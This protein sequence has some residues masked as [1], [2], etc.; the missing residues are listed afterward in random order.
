MIHKYTI[1]V[2]TLFALLVALA[3]PAYAADELR[4]S[5]MR[6][7]KGEYTATLEEM[8]VK[9][10][11]AYGFLDAPA[12]DAAQ[13]QPADETSELPKEDAQTETLDE[14]KESEETLQEEQ[15][16]GD[17]ELEKDCTLPTRTD[18]NPDRLD[19]ALMLYRACGT[20]PETSCPFTD[21]PEEYADAVTWLYETGATK[22]VGNQQ[23]GTGEV[24]E[25]QFIVMLSRL[26]RWETDDIGIIKD[27]MQERGLAPLIAVDGA[28]TF[29]EMYQIVCSLLDH[30]YP[31]RCIPTN[32]KELTPKTMELH[33]DSGADAV[34]QLRKAVTYLPRTVELYFSDDCPQD[35][36]AIFRENLDWSGGRKTMPLLS[37]TN[38]RWY[39]PFEV[40]TVEN[41]H[42]RI[43][44]DSYSRAAEATASTT[45]WLK[46]FKDGQY[47]EALRSFYLSN[48][49]PLKRLTEYGRI[50]Q[51]HDLL[52]R[53]ASY[54]D[55]EYNEA[56]KTATGARPKAH[57][58]VGFME[59]SKIVCDGYAN[60]YSWM[61]MELGVDSY[62]VL[63]RADGGGHAWNKVCMGGNWYNVDACWDDTGRSLRR[64]YLKSDEWM[65]EREHSF[66]DVFST[67]T[68]QS[69]ENYEQRGS[70]ASQ[71]L[72]ET[73][74]FTC[75]VF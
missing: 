57:D 52:C 8:A 22:G 69:S 48:V 68:Y 18:G 49:F 3:L 21:V 62:I 30:A 14:R 16:D 26:L 65:T 44:I 23:F 2:I 50:I 7:P 73:I 33:V 67:K 25:A 12:E 74:I 15:L 6:A 40:Q 55:S 39:F 70:V 64:Y 27:V 20:Q 47:A 66:T 71:S 43:V 38:P 42:I 41:G 1:R 56:M 13:E 58:L 36:I 31:E 75:E 9:R 46:V 60:T 24:T 72:E 37:L 54:D 4:L 29:G 61:L 28:F 10:L 35:D 53:L 17:A 5:D 34:T 59:N 51:C 63:G 32:G 19:A 45:N 11:Y